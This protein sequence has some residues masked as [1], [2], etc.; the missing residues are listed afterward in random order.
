VPPGAAVSPGV[1]GAPDGH[2]AEAPPLTQGG[3]SSR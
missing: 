3:E 2:P 1:E